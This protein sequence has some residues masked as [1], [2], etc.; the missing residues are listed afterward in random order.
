MSQDQYSQYTKT[1]SDVIIPLNKSLS[2]NMKHCMFNSDKLNTWSSLRSLIFKALHM[3]ANMT[4][5]VL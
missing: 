3:S 2:L 4:G 1:E 5:I